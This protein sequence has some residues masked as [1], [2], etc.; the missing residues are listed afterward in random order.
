MEPSGESSVGP[1]AETRNS[2]STSPSGQPVSQPANAFVPIALCHSVCR[3]LCVISS[4]QPSV[5]PAGRPSVRPAG[6]ATVPACAQVGG[7]GMVDKWWTDR[8]CGEVEKLMGMDVWAA[9]VV[10]VVLAVHVVQ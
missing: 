9:R 7:V 6:Q 3:V 10:S 8:G 2:K 5:R 4:C 1:S